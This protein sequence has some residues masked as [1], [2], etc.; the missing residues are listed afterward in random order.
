MIE[1][2]TVIGRTYEGLARWLKY[3]N[4]TVPDEK[5]AADIVIAIIKA[6]QNN[7]TERAKEIIERIIQVTNSPP[8]LAKDVIRQFG[9]LAETCMVLF[10]LVDKFLVKSS[11]KKGNE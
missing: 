10:H 1:I 4:L 7:D 6:Y 3:H 8:E 11:E 9:R 5:E 2:V